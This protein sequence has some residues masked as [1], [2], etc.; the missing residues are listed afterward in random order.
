MMSGGQGHRQNI[1]GGAAKGRRRIHQIT[2]ESESEKCTS[3]L[4]FK[5][6]TLLK[7]PGSALKKPQS[8]AMPLAVNQVSNGVS[9]YHEIFMFAP[10]RCK[11]MV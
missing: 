4:P 11:T 5:A 9:E 10:E 1:A 7:A 8:S 2:T 3:S 6:Y